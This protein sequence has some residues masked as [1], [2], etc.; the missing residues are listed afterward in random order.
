MVARSI[1]SPS[2][3]GHWVEEELDGLDLGHVKLDRRFARMLAD[4]FAH[5]ERS[6]Y[7]S[8]AG[9]AGGKAA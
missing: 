2:G 4:R 3:Q 6:F 8:F 9:K 5:P 1:F 7:A